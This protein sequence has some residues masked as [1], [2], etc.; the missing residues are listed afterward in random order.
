MKF[1][2]KVD[3]MSSFPL[4]LLSMKFRD[5]IEQTHVFTNV[6]LVEACGLSGS[7]AKTMLRRAMEA[8]R[9]ERA[10]RGLYVSKVGR[11]AIER[12]DSFE[13]VSVLDPGAVLSFHSALEAYGVAH[14][15][16]GTCQFRSEAVKAPF[17][18][19]GISYVPYPLVGRLPA[20]MVRGRGGLR[21]VVTT[22]EQ[23]IV[24]SLN[25]PD[26]C[27][28]IEEALMSVSLFSYVDMA[29]LLHL[30]TGESASLAARVGWL[31]E[32]KA[33]DWRVSD[34]V[35]DTLEKMAD[36]GPFKLDKDS[37]RSQGW[38][39]RWRLCLP[40]DGEEAERWVL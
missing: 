32:K 19:S 29:A 40:V 33:N 34:E 28:G 30:A 35:L 31:L 2:G 25:H 17:E 6:Q 37:D 8:G 5:Y 18:H 24:D 21:A 27:G 1:N 10:R 14:N 11:F 36:G 7:T 26:R 9:I 23:T 20:Q 38:S 39:R 12:V 15:I 3:K 22:R 13:L 4:E 16:A